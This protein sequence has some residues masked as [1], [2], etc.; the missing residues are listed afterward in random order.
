MLNIPKWTEILHKISHSW[1]SNRFKKLKT[2]NRN[3]NRQFW[4]SPICHEKK[5]RYAI[6]LKLL[7][8]SGLKM[9]FDEKFTK[10]LSNL[11][12]TKVRVFAPIFVV[13]LFVWVFLGFVSYFSFACWVSSRSKFVWLKMMFAIHSGLILSY[14][15]CLFG[16]FIRWNWKWARNRIKPR[17]LQMFPQNYSN[18]LMSA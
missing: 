10:R 9:S 18:R 4:S 11:N 12:E 5:L 14:I 8:S 2:E 1:I 3:R 7:F 17:K 16:L 6:L 15:F 13:I